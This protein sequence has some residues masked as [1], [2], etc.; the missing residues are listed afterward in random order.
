MNACSVQAVVRHSSFA[1]S[2]KAVDSF[3]VLA[4][5]TPSLARQNA[6]EAPRYLI[7]HRA[8]GH[9][10]GGEKNFDLGPTIVA[11]GTLPRP[12]RWQRKKFGK[13]NLVFAIAAY[14]P[15]TRTLMRFLVC[16]L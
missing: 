2:G 1:E 10:V 4:G 16:P 6:L 5:T 15:A 9:P 12:H 11:I 13:S 8:V 7:E 3:C 14:N